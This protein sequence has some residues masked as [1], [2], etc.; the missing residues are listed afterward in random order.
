MRRTGW[1]VGE[2]L[3]SAS[4]CWGAIFILSF[5]MSLRSAQGA[6]RPGVEIVHLFFQDLL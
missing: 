5:D 2:T 3:E 6:G 1:N 4:L